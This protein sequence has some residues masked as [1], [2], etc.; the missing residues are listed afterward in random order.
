MRLF[1]LLIKGTMA[2]II[3]WIPTGTAV[4]TKMDVQNGYKTTVDGHSLE[5]VVKKTHRKT[6]FLNRELEEWYAVGLVIE[7]DGE[8]FVLTT[9]PESIP[10]KEDEDVELA[11]LSIQRWIE[12]KNIASSLS[13]SIASLLFKS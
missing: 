1:D 6:G 4:E 3:K 5:I 11:C 7:K 9:D 10:G 8:R 2:G 13:R 12:N